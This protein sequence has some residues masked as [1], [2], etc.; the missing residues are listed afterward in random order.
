MMNN[1]LIATRYFILLSFSDDARL[2]LG[3]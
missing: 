3:A 2:P 1:A